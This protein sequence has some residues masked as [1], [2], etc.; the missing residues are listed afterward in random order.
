MSGVPEAPA[1]P[2][3]A[4]AAN[5]R[6]LRTLKGITQETLADRADLHF[7]DISRIERGV[8]EPGVRTVVKLARGLELPAAELMRF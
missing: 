5:L 2:L 4:F 7:S 1:D 8:R 3:P 6:R